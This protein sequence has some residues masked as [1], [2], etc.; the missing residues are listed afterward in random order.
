M[1]TPE[2]NDCSGSFELHGSDMFG[3]DGAC[4]FVGAHLYVNINTVDPVLKDNGGPTWTH[5]LIPGNDSPLEYDAT[6]PCVD[7]VGQP[8][9][10]DQRSAP[11]LAQGCHSGAYENGSVVP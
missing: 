9:L 8:L 4:T 10:T 11:R 1:D 7:E 3:A 2:Y 6:E 5:G